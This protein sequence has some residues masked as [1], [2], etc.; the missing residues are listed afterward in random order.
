MPVF[1]V[2]IPTYNRLALLPRPL[3]SVWAQ[4]FTNFGVIV[5]DDGSAD[6][7]LKAMGSFGKR[8]PWKSG[9]CVAPN[10]RFAASAGEYVQWFDADD[11]LV[12]AKIA[13]QMRVA[14]ENPMSIGYGHNNDALNKTVGNTQTGHFIRKFG[15][16][17]V[18]RD[19]PRYANS[20]TDGYL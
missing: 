10:R 3:D 1:S 13:A 5:T 16:S 19:T 20:W 11:L 9:G 18:R 17:K 14:D 6:R 15:C 8:V 12:S 2:I 4:H 7:S